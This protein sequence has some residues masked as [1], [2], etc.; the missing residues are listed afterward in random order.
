MPLAAELAGHQPVQVVDLP[1]FGL[2]GDRAGSWT[3]LST[4]TTWPTG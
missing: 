1:S 4:P 2:S 3:S